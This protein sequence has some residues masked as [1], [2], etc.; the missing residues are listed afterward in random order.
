MNGW[1][2]IKHHPTVIPIKQRV[3]ESL[4]GTLRDFGYGIVYSHCRVTVNI[5]SQYMESH[6]IPRFQTTNQIINVLS[7]TLW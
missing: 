3:S 7:I 4:R 6:K 2:G 5:V 1:D